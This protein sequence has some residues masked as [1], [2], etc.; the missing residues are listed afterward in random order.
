M[1]QNLW[2]AYFLSAGALLTGCVTPL[3]DSPEEASRQ[4][5]QAW[6]D[7]LM[8]FDFDGSYGF[9]SPAYQSA[10]SAG[11]YSS[12]YAGRGMWK[13]ASLGDI[14]CDGAEEFGVCKVEVIVTYRGFLMKEDMTTVLTETWVHIDRVWYTQPRS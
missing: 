1:R 6:L 5:A 2:M 12:K 8:A 13:T 10:H 4:R 7:A 14:R 9:T 11:Y 3:T